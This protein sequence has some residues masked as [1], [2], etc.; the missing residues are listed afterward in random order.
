MA[1]SWRTHLNLLIGILV[2]AVAIYLSFRKINFQ[3]LWDSLRSVNYWYLIPAFAVLNICFFLKGLSWRYLLTPAKEGISAMTTTTV[4][5]IGLM[6][7]DLF[8]AKMGELARAYLM[9]EKEKLPKTLCLSTIMVEHLLDI[10]ILSLFLL[11]LLPL[12]SIPAWLRSSGILVGWVAL[13]MVGLLVL[14][15]RQEE[16]CLTWLRRL[17]PRLPE[18]I[19]GKIL[20][21]L[22]NIIQ[23]FRVVTGRYIFYSLASL[24]GMWGVVFIFTYFVMIAFGL[25]LPF[26][27][28]V[29][30]VI[31]TAFGK[32]IPS[33]PGAIGTYHY[34]VIV[35]LMAF[36]ISKEIALSYAIVLHAFGFLVEVAVGVVFL[37]TGHVSL[38][39][40]TR[41]AEESP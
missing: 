32:I 9:G 29:V 35:V 39:K 5:V 23:G 37:F 2:S 41:G 27:A 26:Y 30:V 36:G 10:L 22:G 11:F 16:K 12:V 19:Q 1:A 6:V 20:A 15:M 31:F 3:V 13:G 33:S 17:M 34:L 7:N 8:P 40:I 18:R 21:A 24:F 38:V 28:A 4:L 25:T 14:I